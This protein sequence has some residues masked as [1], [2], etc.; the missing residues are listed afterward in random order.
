VPA[1]DEQSPRTSVA[2]RTAGQLA[3]VVAA[4]FLAGVLTF[5]AQG[6]LPESL[7]SFANSASGWTLVTAVVV[8]ALRPA[9]PTAA[10]L[11]AV[12]FVLLTLGYATAAAWQG[13]YYDPR[14]FAAVGLLVGPF[15]GLAATWLH[16][17]GRPAA[18]GAALLA[19]IGIGESAY[20]LL[21]LSETTSPVYWA[22]IGVLGL[23]LIVHTAVRRSGGP[24]VAATACAG[25]AVVATAF[26][27]AY[28][29]L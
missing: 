16:R 8:W 28:S 14:F 7:Q 29:A 15:V 23:A 12:G 18:A 21:H 5:S 26:V 3:V 2:V 20:G 1:L 27:L 9:S 19:G 24:A 6:F 10:V 13:L 25:C 4:T 17:P 11:G 22:V